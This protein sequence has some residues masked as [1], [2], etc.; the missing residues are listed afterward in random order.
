MMNVLQT[1]RK[2]EAEQAAKHVE[3]RAVNMRNDDSIL[4]YDDSMLQNDD[5]I[6]KQ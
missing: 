3:I 4:N 6:L 5:F 1:F 2:A